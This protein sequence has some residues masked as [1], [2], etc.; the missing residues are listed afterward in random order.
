M[1]Q[2]FEKTTLTKGSQ[3]PQAIDQ[4]MQDCIDICTECL[5]S[6]EQLIWHCLERGGEHASVAH[7][8]LLQDCAN[9]CALSAK[10]MLRQSPLHTRICS[11]CAEACLQ[12]AVSCEKIGREDA[13][14]KSCAEV[15][16]QCADSCN[17]MAR[18]H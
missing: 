16:R 17:E 6:C 12:S 8:R 14:M 9:L 4:R 18:Q 10:F 15:C 3:T 11:V 7:I 13:E 2:Q 5:Q 1:E